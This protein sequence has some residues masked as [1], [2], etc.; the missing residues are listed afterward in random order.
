MISWLNLGGVDARIQFWRRTR[1]GKK[2][3]MHSWGDHRNIGATVAKVKC[4][5]RY[6]LESKPICSQKVLWARLEVCQFEVKG[7]IK[8]L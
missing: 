8:V 3:L 1:K 2:T 4:Q 6:D 7:S 5:D